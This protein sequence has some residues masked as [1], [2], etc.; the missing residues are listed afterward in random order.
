MVS[1]SG[2][3]M[4]V[5]VT[6]IAIARNSMLMSWILLGPRLHWARA[7]FTPHYG[8]LGLIGAHWGSFIRVRYSHCARP[9]CAAKLSTRRRS[10]QP[11]NAAHLDASEFVARH[12]SAAGLIARQNRSM[13]ARSL[14]TDRNKAR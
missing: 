9:R 7:A 6:G 1:D 4:N 10:L 8:S 14:L 2:S 11:P 12:C 3:S 13:S 5:N